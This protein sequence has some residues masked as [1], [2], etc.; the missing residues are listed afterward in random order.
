MLPK[1]QRLD[2]RK[3]TE[4]LKTSLKA[5]TPFFRLYFVPD[6]KIQQIA[7]IV[8]KKQVHKASERNKIKRF[9]KKTMKSVF[10]HGFTGK[11]VVYAKKPIIKLESLQLEKMIQKK[12]SEF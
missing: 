1:H 12:L 2:L 7:I 5:S 4:I 6:S 10:K 11:I 8:P 3:E 9:V